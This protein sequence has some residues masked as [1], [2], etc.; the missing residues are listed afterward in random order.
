[1]SGLM[2]NGTV[3]S[4]PP[5][6]PKSPPELYGRRRDLAKVQILEREIGFLE[7]ELKSIE[8]LQLAS[9]SCKEVVEFVTANVDPLIPTTKKTRRSCRF[10]KWLCGGLSCFKVSWI[11]CLVA[12][13]VASAE[14]PNA[15]AYS[16]AVTYPN[17]AAARDQSVRLVRLA[18]ARAVNAVLNVSG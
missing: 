14:C 6:Q 3:P 17:A 18:L 7:E 10:W 2:G 8:G 9:R 11:C 4:L 5:P 1:M 16:H 13:H 12:I 15:A